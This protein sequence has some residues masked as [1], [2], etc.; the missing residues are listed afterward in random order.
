[1]WNLL[2]GSIRRGRPRLPRGIRIYAIGDVHGRADLV[3]RVFAKIDSDIARHPADRIIELFVG[4]YIDRG[5]ESREV[6]DRLIDRSWWH[7]TVFLRGNHEHF[8]LEFLQNPAALRDWRQYGG[9]ETLVSYDL[10]PSLNADSAEQNEL[11]R[12]LMKRMPLAHREFFSSLRV[13]FTCGDFFF[14]HAGLKPGVSLAQQ[15]E[16]DLL[17][18][19]DDFLLCEDNFE[20]FVVHGHTP[21]LEPDVRRNRANIDTGAYAT[22]NLTCLMF[23]DDEAFLI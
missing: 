23:E 8:V 14:V 6:I 13:S 5:P 10:T 18:I 19:R 15:K 21:V 4:D 7:E 11:S 20:K 22:G 12:E 9:L 2:T 17:W 3:Q 1:M 16:E